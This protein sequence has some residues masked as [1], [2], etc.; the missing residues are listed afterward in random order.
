MLTQAELKVLLSY[1]AETGVLTRNTTGLPVTRNISQGY[2]QV[3]LHNRLYRAHRLIWML[4]YGESPNRIDHV[5]G[6]RE[7][8]RLSNL[9]KVSSSENSKNQR[10]RDDNKSGCAGVNWHSRTKRWIAQIRDRTKYVYLG[11]FVELSDAIAARKQAEKTFGYHE[12][13]GQAR[14]RYGRI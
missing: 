14:P 9:R 12:N 3:R 2:I 5:N 7:D 11:C 6:D 13:H 1:D 4:V 8:N 10:L